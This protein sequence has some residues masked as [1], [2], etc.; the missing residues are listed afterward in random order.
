MRKFLIS[1]A[2]MASTVAVAAPA[3]AQWYP[4]GYGYNYN[5]GQVRRLQVRIV[6]NDLRHMRHDR[7]VAHLQDTLLQR[8]AVDRQG[9]GLADADVG[10]RRL[11][12]VEADEIAACDRR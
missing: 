8:R 5:Y 4:Q 10:Q 12:L 7:Q 2:L 6:G 11:V 1:A 9:Q 3:S